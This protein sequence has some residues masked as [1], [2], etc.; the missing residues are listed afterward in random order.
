MIEKWDARLENWALWKTG[1]QTASASSGAYRSGPALEWWKCPP[2]KPQALVGDALD[3]DRLI[4]RL[5]AEHQEAI[6]VVYLWTY[7]ESLEDRARAMDPPVHR[8]T[9]TNR[10]NAAKV[11]LEGLEQNRVAQV[12]RALAAVRD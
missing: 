6:R 3:V 8:N 5:T 11:A 10:V 12:R 1:A 7:P 2:R 9:L 4:Q